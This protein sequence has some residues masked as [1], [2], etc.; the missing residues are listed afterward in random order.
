MNHSIM[1][2]ND[3]MTPAENQ[4]PSSGSSG[5]GPT[6]ATPAQGAVETGNVEVVV[7]KEDLAKTAVMGFPEEEQKK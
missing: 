5:S 3:S 7:S 4:S 1:S 2:T 6:P